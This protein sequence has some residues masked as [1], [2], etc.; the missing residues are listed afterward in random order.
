[1]AGIDEDFGVNEGY[2]QEQTSVRE[3]G[4]ILSASTRGG[5]LSSWWG[6]Q[7][8]HCVEQRQRE[9]ER[10]LWVRASSDDDPVKSP[11]RGVTLWLEVRT[12]AT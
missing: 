11:R 1:M 2:M 5:F 8:A 6:Q 9:R 7:A 3:L 12:I 10:L 4:L